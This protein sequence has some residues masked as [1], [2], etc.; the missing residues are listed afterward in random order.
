MSYIS[1]KRCKT[2]VCWE[3]VGFRRHRSLTKLT[4]P[5]IIVKEIWRSFNV[6]YSM[7]ESATEKRSTHDLETRKQVSSVTEVCRPE[8]Q[9]V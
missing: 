6:R 5:L 4:V 1:E 2:K 8:G 3:I 7:K 9:Q